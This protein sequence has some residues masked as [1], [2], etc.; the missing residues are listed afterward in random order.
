MAPT[1]P[2]M[3]VDLSKNGNKGFPFFECFPIFG[4][5]FLPV[6]C[7]GWNGVRSGSRKVIQQEVEFSHGSAHKQGGV[8]G[9]DEL[10]LVR[11]GL[12]WTSAFHIR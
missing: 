6:H 4:C 12:L 11:S 1:C 8:R 2:V 9:H 5:S 7:R 3:G 10:S